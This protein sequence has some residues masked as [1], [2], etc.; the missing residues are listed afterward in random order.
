MKILLDSNNIALFIGQD[1]EVTASCILFSDGSVCNSLNK[2]NT[3]IIDADAPNPP[4]GNTWKWEKDTWVCINQAVVDAYNQSEKD[5]F[6][7]SQ[8]EAR[9]KAYST[10]ADPLFFKAQRGKATIKE[11]ENK[12]AEIDA[13][14]PYKY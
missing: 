10:E 7:I 13:R 6:N 4:L 2:D 11:W 12:I 3:V 8:K 14:Y 5:I 9:A 1:F